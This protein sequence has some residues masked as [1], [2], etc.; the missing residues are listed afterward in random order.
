MKCLKCSNEAILRIK[1]HKA[2][3]CSDHLIEHLQNQMT[4]SLKKFKML[5]PYS[6]V[7]V[8]ISGGKD[9]LAL[10]DMLLDQ[11]Y[12]AHGFYIDLGI[13]KYSE[14]SKEKVEKFAQQV[15][16]KLYTISLPEL[17][18]VGIEEI[19]QNNPRS[20]CSACGLI[21][22]YVM[23]II[24]KAGGY[25][26]VA[27]G[28]N[29]DDEASSL[30]GNTLRWQTGYLSRQSPSMPAKDGLSKKIK[31]LCRLAER[32]TAAYCITKN[33]DYILEECPMSEGASTFDYKEVMNKLELKSPGT[34]D[35][36][37]LGFLRT[38]QPHFQTH[39]N[40]PELDNCPSC[41]EPTITP[42]QNCSF[43]RQMNSKDLGPLKLKSYIRNLFG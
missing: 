11:G 17:Y 16:G 7:I 37:Y 30:L 15:S 31:P 4:K 32:E 18:S 1:R 38:G 2:A 41:G 24:A 33:I 40:E 14:K 29:L 21:K 10:W 19:S 8:A 36:F 28:H 5:P 27:T 23:N 26:A 25:H 43:C 42:E 3:F 6:K 9:S 39:D 20:A 13:D 35:Q 22:R 34:K 12:E